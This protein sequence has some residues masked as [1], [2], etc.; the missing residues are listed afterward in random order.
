MAAPSASRASSNPPNDSSGK[1]E[2]STTAAD[3]AVA[4][5]IALVLAFG[6]DAF[7]FFVSCFSGSD[8][9]PRT[10]AAPAGTGTS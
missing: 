8:P 6:D 10:L 2:S 7:F 3:T 5:A 9:D 4:D 1:S